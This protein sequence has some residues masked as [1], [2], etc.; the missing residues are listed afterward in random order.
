M[1]SIWL[2]GGFLLLA[3]AACET[4]DEKLTRLKAKVAVEC[5][6]LTIDESRGTNTVSHE[7]RNR[8]DLAQRD[9]NRFMR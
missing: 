1:K 3:L 5:I 2:F 8:C 7:Q 4:D 9:L 6:P